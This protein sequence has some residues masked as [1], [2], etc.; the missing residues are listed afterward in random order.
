MQV[1]NRPVLLIDMDAFT[2]DWYC[3]RYG[4]GREAVQPIKVRGGGEQAERTPTVHSA[5]GVLVCI[6]LHAG[7][8]AGTDP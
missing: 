5:A 4:A 6:C 1:Y 8:Q 2:R 7:C 3:R